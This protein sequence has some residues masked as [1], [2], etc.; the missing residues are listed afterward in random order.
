M[1]RLSLD[2]LEG[3]W[4]VWVLATGHAISPVTT[5]LACVFAA[6]VAVTITLIGARV[7]APPPLTPDAPQVRG[8]GGYAGPGSLGGTPSTLSRR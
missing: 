5:L 2:P 1:D 4:Y 6:I 7:G 8:P 3:L